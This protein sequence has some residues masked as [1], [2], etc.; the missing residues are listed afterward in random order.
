MVSAFLGVDFRAGGILIP[1]AKLEQFGGRDPRKTER[2]TT[3][4][5]METLKKRAGT[6]L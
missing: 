6:A 4:A 1:R 2:I 3:E 5:D